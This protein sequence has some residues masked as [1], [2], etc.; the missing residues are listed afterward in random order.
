[1]VISSVN[2]CAT[3]KAQPVKK[4]SADLNIKPVAAAASIPTAI[5]VGYATKLYLENKG[6]TSA[7]IDCLKKYPDDVALQT[8]KELTEK[9]MRNAKWG[10]IA[11]LTAGIAT[12][13][14]YTVAKI[15]KSDTPEVKVATPVKKA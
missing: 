5:G 6:K 12:I 4:N 8:C 3:N 9:G 7:Y 2:F 14:G 1:M 15:F 10:G 11:V 13:A